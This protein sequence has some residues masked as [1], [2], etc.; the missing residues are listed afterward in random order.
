MPDKQPTTFEAIDFPAARLSR[1]SRPFTLDYMSKK[2]LLFFSFKVVEML[3]NNSIRV[4][5][6]IGFS[7]QVVTPFQFSESGH[8]LHLGFQRNFKIPEILGFKSPTCMIHHGSISCAALSR[9]F[10]K[11]KL[12]TGIKSSLETL[13]LQYLIS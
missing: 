5:V 1:Q 9:S 6:Y 7:R 10:Y 13:L 12:D 3:I 4:T 2:L 8:K 11:K